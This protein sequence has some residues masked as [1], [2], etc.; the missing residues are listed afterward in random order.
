MPSLE[1]H[2]NQYHLNTK[3]SVLTAFTLSGLAYTKRHWQ[4]AKDG[5]SGKWGHRAIAII[6]A[7]PVIG[8]IAALIERLTFAIKHRSARPLKNRNVTPTSTSELTSS[9][10]A[11]TFLRTR[12]TSTTPLQSKS[13][14]QE[15]ITPS[16]SA[17]SSSQSLEE[18]ERP[19]LQ[20]A[21]IESEEELLEYKN[22]ADLGDRNAQNALGVYFTSRDP[23]IAT[24]YFELAAGQ[25]HAEAQWH[26]A[27]MELTKLGKKDYFKVRGLLQSSADKGFAPAFAELGELFLKGLGGEK[28]KSQAKKLFE[29]GVERGDPS[30]CMALADL[31]EKNEPEKAAKLYKNAASYRYPP[32]MYKLAEYYERG[33]GLK[34]NIPKAIL[35]YEQLLPENPRLQESIDR[36]KN[37]GG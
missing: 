23:D 13:E 15:E 31:C 32:A 19:A 10:S 2:N 3:E 14:S 5:A 30:A 22:K 24:Y 12:S 26:L 36:L 21:R 35:L 1:R 28:S 4:L 11:T 37:L 7:I 17:S 8:G 29:M 33:I 25:H 6:E 16:P 9:S 20:N 18:H 34:K 27:F